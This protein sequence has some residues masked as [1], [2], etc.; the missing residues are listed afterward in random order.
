MRGAAGSNDDADLP[1]EF[2]CLLAGIKHGHLNFIWR[3]G[4]PM[5]DRALHDALDLGPDD[6]IVGFLYLGTP[7]I[8]PK[9][10]S[11]ELAADDLVRRL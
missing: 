9:P 11:H 1:S 4:W 10:A 2:A 8:V 3:S 5:F 7:T 6:Q